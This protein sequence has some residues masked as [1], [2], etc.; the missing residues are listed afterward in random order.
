MGACVRACVPVVHLFGGFFLHFSYVGCIVAYLLTYGMF[1]CLFVY[2]YR[3]VASAYIHQG[4]Q[5]SERGS[6]RVGSIV[7]TYIHTSTFCMKASL[8]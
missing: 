7:Y 8:D 5:R 2:L 1:V 6:G 3:Y 4:A